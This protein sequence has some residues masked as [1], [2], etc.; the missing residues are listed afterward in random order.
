MNYRHIYHA[1]NFADVFKHIVLIAITKEFL[2]KDKP[3]CYLDTHAGVGAYDLSSQAAQKSKEYETGI[4]KI[5]SQPN[6]PELVKAYL[7]I[8][9]NDENRFFYPGSPYFVKKLIRPTDHMILCELQQD[10]CQQL[11]RTFPHDKQ[12]AIHCQDAYLGLKAFLPPKEKRGFVLIDP[13]YEK[14]DELTQLTT[15][16]PDAIK[17]WETGTFA[18]WYPIKNQ[19]AIERFI[20]RLKEK[21]QRPALNVQLSIYPEDNAQQLNG[22]GMFIVNPPWKLE[23]ELQNVLPWLWQTLSHNQ[24]GQYR[25]EAI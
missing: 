1:G 22:S 4:G 21:I 19:T 23:E 25:I 9:K 14:P 8:V 24:Q 11:K 20:H 17:R 12:V 6:S 18:L 10:E 7:Q 13:P 5:L 2:H 3:F 16:L 15:I